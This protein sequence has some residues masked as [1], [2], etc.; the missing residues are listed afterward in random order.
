VLSG[1][2]VPTIGGSC[3]ATSSSRIVIVALALP[4]VAPPV[5]AERLSVKVLFGSTVVSFEIG[6]GTVL[7]VCPGVKVSV[8]LTAE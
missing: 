4:S 1:G 6:I 3:C 2:V 5:G 8:P 7:D